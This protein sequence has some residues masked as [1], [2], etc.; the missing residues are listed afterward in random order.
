MT[1]F[2]KLPPVQVVAGIIL[3]DENV[4]DLGLVP[5]AAR[6]TKEEKKEIHEKV[7]AVYLRML[8]LSS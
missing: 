5:H 1:Y 2:G 4:V 8:A 6:Q 3:E 7:S